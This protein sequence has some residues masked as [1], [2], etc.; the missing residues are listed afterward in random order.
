[1]DRRAGSML[2][3]LLFVL[4]DDSEFSNIFEGVKVMSIIEMFIVAVVAT[5]LLVLGIAFGFRA[6]LSRLWTFTVRMSVAAWETTKRFVVDLV[7]NWRAATILSFA[8]LGLASFGAMYLAWSPY[9]LLFT[10]ALVIYLLAG[11]GPSNEFAQ[12]EPCEEPVVASA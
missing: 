8:V 3:L 6:L 9:A 10:A 4:G 7:T 5:V 1:M 12:H 2:V 11:E